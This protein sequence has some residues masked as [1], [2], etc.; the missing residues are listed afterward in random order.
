[1]S[2]LSPARQQHCG[3]KITNQNTDVFFNERTIIARSG[4]LISFQMGNEVTTIFCSEG[5]VSILCNCIDHTSMAGPNYQD[6]LTRTKNLSADEN[7]SLWS[8][9]KKYFENICA[10]TECEWYWLCQGSLCSTPWEW[11]VEAEIRWYLSSQHWAAF[12]SLMAEIL[13]ILLQWAS[14]KKLPHRRR[15]FLSAWLTEWFSYD[16]QTKSM[17]NI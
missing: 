6:T 4:V 13:I 17:N 8:R 14:S 15:V 2:S 10:S 11:R 16:S 1:M 7:N 12:V 5:W 9:I 3:L